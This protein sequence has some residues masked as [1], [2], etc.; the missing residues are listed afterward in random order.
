MKKLTLTQTIIMLSVVMISLQLIY[1]VIS[2]IRVN[3]MGHHLGVVE[4]QLVPI[5]EHMVL[6]MEYQLEQEIEFERTFRYA[7]EMSERPLAINELKQSVK[8]F[9]ELTIKVD[10]ELDS[11]SK[12]IQLAVSQMDDENANN[13]LLNLGKELALIK[14]KHTKWVEDIQG[15][16]TLLKAEKINAAIVASHPIEEQIKELEKAVFEKLALTEKLTAQVLHKVKEEEESI[17]SFSIGMLI[18]SIV[19]S[20]ALT[21][22]ITSNLNNDLS[23]LST[24]VARMAGG[25]VFDKVTS[26]LGKEFGLNTMRQNLHDV[27]TIVERTSNEMLD[28]SSE[29]AQVSAEISQTADLQSQEIELISTAMTEMEATSQEVARH[30]ESTKASTAEATATTA[31]TKETTSNAMVAISKLTD[32]LNLSSENLAELE[33]N[34]ANIISV[35][36]VI[37]AIADQTNLLALNA[38]I[39]AARAGDQGRGFA[40]V[41][42]EVRNL[43][44]RTQDSTVEIESMLTLFSQGTS[45]A[46]SSMADSIVYGEE[47]NL[48]ASEANSKLDI[49]Q[50]EIEEIN[51]MN[52]QIATA[53]EEQSCTTQELS[54]NTIRVNQLTNESTTSIA[55]ISTA[56]EELAQISLS[57]KERLS[58]FTLS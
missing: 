8:H 9:D 28:A 43:A 24:E 21:R 7:F 20:A 13:Q 15:V 52:S 16:F 39:E 4:T 23:A 1:G 29:L 45:D 41:A 42:D 38:A 47:S 58:K 31:T 49:I 19:V 14:K 18:F 51:D 11:T 34:S 57:L 35:L 25:N 54:Q 55:Q 27:L 30:A 6:V 36:D 56:S 48:A 32:S 44:K 37:K 17:L 26:K 2:N 40:V 50:T 3:T 12:M 10:K 33:K 53:A 46:V 22:W 5:N